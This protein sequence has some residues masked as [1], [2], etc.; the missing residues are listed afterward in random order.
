ME[1][2]IH[3][4]NSKGRSRKVSAHADVFS[5]PE[6]V[7]RPFAHLLNHTHT[8][9][10]HKVGLRNTPSFGNAFL[11][12]NIND[13]L[14]SFLQITQLPPP[15]T[16][17]S[18]IFVSITSQPSISLV[19][20]YPGSTSILCMP[21]CLV[22]TRKLSMIPSLVS[23]GKETG[24]R[25]FEEPR[26]ANLEELFGPQS[27]SPFQSPIQPVNIKKPCFCS[28]RCG[29]KARVTLM[30]P[31]MRTLNPKACQHPSSSLSN[32]VHVDVHSIQSTSHF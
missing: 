3:I 22:S 13:D 12:H 20:K 7:Q 26:I 10:S 21:R 15:P 24:S 4:H 17:Y 30:R 2:P 23:A 29:V 32:L 19:R 14:G 27:A 11:F 9:G 25:K 18:V 1:Y 5:L 8:V 28:L 31:N 6:T 16:S